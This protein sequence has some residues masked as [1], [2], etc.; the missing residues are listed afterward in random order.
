[1]AENTFT[2]SAFSQHL[3]EHKLMGTE[4]TACGAQFLPP[5]PMCAECF[6]DQMRWVEMG[7][8]GTLTAFTVVHIASTA[9]IVAGFGRENPHCSGIV[10]LENGPSISAQILGVDTS[11]PT[12]I[13]V[14]SPVEA[15]FLERGE[16]D[17]QETFLAFELLA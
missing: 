2:K 3:A 16:G 1:M 7:T 13:K 8:R 9:M 5:R 17:Q 10:Q 6:S 14:G 15:V 12:L 11:N 4:C